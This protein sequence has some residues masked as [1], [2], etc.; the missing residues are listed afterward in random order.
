MMELSFYNNGHKE[1]Y[2]NPLIDEILEVDLCKGAI[3]YSPVFGELCYDGKDGRFLY[4][5]RV[6]NKE[7]VKFRLDGS[8]ADHADCMLFPSKNKCYVEAWKEVQSKYPKSVE[9]TCSRNEKLKKFLPLEGSLLKISGFLHSAEKYF[10]EI[11]CPKQSEKRKYYLEL[12]GY[13]NG[14]PGISGDSRWE[15]KEFGADQSMVYL[16]SFCDKLSAEKFIAAF[17]PLLYFFACN[18]FKHGT[19]DS[20]GEVNEKVVFDKNGFPSY[21]P[22]GIDLSYFYEKGLMERPIRRYR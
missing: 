10:N 22:F 13:Y 19:S 17:K 21:V 14:V 5:V 6:Y 18:I 4:F 1:T 7:R 20:K 2:K 11:A 12:T 9:E 3:V 16:F 15:I 8:L